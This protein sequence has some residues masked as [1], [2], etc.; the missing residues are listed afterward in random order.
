MDTTF[1]GFILN[2]QVGRAGLVTVTLLLLD[3]TMR[4]FV[5]EDLDADPE[6]FNER[7]S[8]LAILRDAMNESEPV[9]IRAETSESGDSIVQVT[10][11]SRDA[12]RGASTEDL[13]VSEGLVLAISLLSRVGIGGTFGIE[14]S[15]IAEIRIL[16]A[17]IQL[18]TLQ[19]DMQMPERLVAVE[20][21]H[22]FRDAERSGETVTVW[23][24][25]DKDQGRR[26]VGVRVGAS[27]LDNKDP[28]NELNGFVETLSLIR[29]FAEDMANLALVRFTTAPAFSGEGN[30]IGLV[31]FLP[32]TVNL[33]V[34][35]GSPAYALFEAALRDTLRMRVRAIDIRR[36][37]KPRDPRGDRQPVPAGVSEFG[38]ASFAARRVAAS[39]AAV[40]SDTA[41]RPEYFLALEAELVA[42]LASASRPV[43]IMIS[44]EQLDNGP[45]DFL[46][47]PGLPTSDLVPRSLRDLNI[48]YTAAWHGYGCFNHGV[49]RFQFTLENKFRVMVDGKELC[50]YES[51]VPPVKLAYA[52]L[53]GDHQVVVEIENWTCKLNY[54]MDVYRVR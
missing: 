14:S 15:D 54:A 21:L 19:L 10:R 34:L 38:G 28:G 2:I 52:C 20:M 23:H 35:K 5:I 45:E 42:P 30:T 49:Y 46:C 4:S 53:G 31:P 47:T 37:Q 6:R 32:E 7:L 29:D 40:S 8:K 18:L 48:P 11:L 33:I 36:D 3:G 51:S 43:W 12:H 9:E 16:T 17:D 41:V 44:R 26:V 24:I 39:T 25:A 13:V 1:R 22:S 50:L 27:S